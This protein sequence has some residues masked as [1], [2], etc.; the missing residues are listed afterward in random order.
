MQN[1][2][3]ALPAQSQHTTLR[4]MTNVTVNMRLHQPPREM[5]Y[6][7][8]SEHGAD[9][10]SQSVY[11]QTLQHFNVLTYSLIKHFHTTL[12]RKL[13]PEQNAENARLI[14]NASINCTQCKCNWNNRGHL[15][16]LAECILFRLQF[17]AF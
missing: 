17:I 8:F 2:S 4:M 3:F 7:K 11:R 9:H 14:I 6:I 12:D 16:I 13:H 1:V 10:Y 15:S 5:T